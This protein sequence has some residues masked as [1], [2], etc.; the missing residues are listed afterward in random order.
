MIFALLDGC[1]SFFYTLGSNFYKY[2]NIVECIAH[3]LH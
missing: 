3:E 2:P 1:N